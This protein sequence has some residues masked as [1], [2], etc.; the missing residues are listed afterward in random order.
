MARLAPTQDVIR[1]LFASSGNKCAFPDCKE[2]LIDKDGNFIGQMCHIEA[3]N[4]GGERYNPHSNDE[5]RRAF[6]N[7]LLL[8]YKHHV[9]TDDVSAYSVDDL[10]L[11]KKNHELQF[12]MSP[13]EISQEA[14]KKLFRKFD[15][16]FEQIR[17]ALSAQASQLESG[18]EINRD[19]N[20]LTRKIFSLLT[21]T[22]QGFLNDATIFV[23]R[24]SFLKELREKGK[25]LTTYEELIAFKEKNW[26]NLDE[27]LQYKVL[28]NLAGTLFDLHRELEAGSFL[29]Q[30]ALLNYKTS[31]SL[32]FLAL[33]YSI[34]GDEEKFLEVFQ[35]PM[36][37]KSVNVNLWLAFINVYK[38]IMQP[39]DLRNAVPQTLANTPEILFALGNAFIETGDYEAGRKLLDCSLE[40]T[41]DSIEKKWKLQAIIATEKLIEKVTSDKIVFQSFSKQDILEINSIISILTESWDYVR[42]KELARPSW[43]IVMNRGFAYRTLSDF[44]NAERDLEEAWRLGEHFDAFR[45]LVI[46]YCDT[47]QFEKT[48]GLFDFRDIQNVAEYDRLEYLKLKARFV[49]LTSSADE[50]NFLLEAELN[51]ANGV[52]RMQ[53]LNQIIL[54]YFEKGVVGKV[55]Q[56]ID[57]LISIFPELPHGYLHKVSYLRR[58]NQDTGILHL[59]NKAK[60]IAISGVFE[61]WIWLDIAN[62]YYAIKK[63]DEAI[64]CYE[65]ITNYRYNH[66]AARNLILAKFY[67]GN[68]EEA[69]LQSKEIVRNFEKDITGNEILFR[70]YDATNRTEEAVKILEE[71]LKFGQEEALDHFRLLGIRFYIKQNKA[72]DIKRLLLKI[73][74]PYNFGLQEQFAIAAIHCDFADRKEGFE[75]AYNSRINNLENAEAHQLYIDHTI[76]KQQ[77]TTREE[78]FPMH[79][80]SETAVKLKDKRGNS[81][82][83]FITDDSRVAGTHILRSNNSFTHL[84]LGKTLESEVAM[85]NSVGIG[86]HLIVSEICSKY[87]FAFRESMKLMQTTF[88]GQSSMVVFEGD[89]HSE[90]EFKE[91]LLQQSRSV[92]QERREILQ[93][94]NGGFITIG[95]LGQLLG[96]HVI[97]TWMNL[98]FEDSIGISCFTTNE[99]SAVIWTLTENRPVVLEITS[100]LTLA[101]L[102]DKLDLL[103]SHLS[104]CYIAQATFNEII[105]FRQSLEE[106]RSQMSLNFEGEL[107]KNVIDS[108]NMDRQKSW[109]DRMIKWCKNNTTILT[110]KKITDADMSGADL[111]DRLD[112]A[113][114]QSLQLSHELGA[115]LLSDDAKLKVIAENKFNVRSFSSYQFLTHLVKENSIPLSVYSEFSRLLVKANYIYI[116]VTGDDLWVLYEQSGFKTD[117][118]LARAVRGLMIL[119]L[120]WT[121]KTIAT[122]AKKLYLNITLASVRES[123]L[124]LTLNTAKRRKDFGH[125]KAGLFLIIELEFYLL[126][127]Q[128]EDFKQLIS[129]Y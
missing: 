1:R 58:T 112:N 4:P 77:N 83:Y 11:M 60:E 42:G 2:N 21:S 98:V 129:M 97:R 74:N 62:G 114:Y 79:V 90:K 76:G 107:I 87:V 15:Q 24:L 34:E 57:Q 38:N 13:Y 101:V 46:L 8:C 66:I 33:G 39:D 93:L 84:V 14:E 16:E 12:M 116:P 55:Q 20:D 108:R 25:S 121:V 49:L 27:E 61:N 50:A 100:L 30:L 75:I 96:Q 128:K 78:M 80:A 45:N 10:R 106:Q 70:I 67:S 81:T 105:H 35:Q 72:D 23:E 48:R 44:H 3:A 52:D 99:S 65:K 125:V 19:T 6:D 71:Y 124:M 36:L 63:Y 115:A 82:T 88:A 123:A 92:D 69:E 91:Y 7:L 22:K 95:V 47:K 28:V 113:S 59:L 104:N 103:E 126:P 86:S 118:I 102:S 29:R 9:K 17:S 56:Y 89:Q 122:F 68:Y 32:S 31:D 119:D 54:G 51:N 73:A 18:N 127:E 41:D 64:E 37:E 43:H 117:T 40:K 120:S 94:Y 26:D 85:P 5:Q 111:R 53:L 109:L 110:P